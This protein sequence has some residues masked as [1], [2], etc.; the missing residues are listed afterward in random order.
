M[1]NKELLNY[2]NHVIG[3][4]FIVLYAKHLKSQ[5]N[6][7]LV[8]VYAPCNAREKTALWEVITNIKLVNQTYNWCVL[9]DFNAVRRVNERKGKSVRSNQSS[10][11]K[12]F[13]E[14]IDKNVLLEIRIVGR[15]FTWYKQNG[16]IKSRLD[17]ILVSI[18]WLQEWP[19]SKQNI[20]VREISNQC[21]IVVKSVVKD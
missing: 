15:R 9:G 21:A 4:G 5:K 14:F 1:W 8:N 16:T 7:A 17:R 3:K 2:D 12:R 13:N 18:E 11:T 20:Q 19:L 6:I 10:Q